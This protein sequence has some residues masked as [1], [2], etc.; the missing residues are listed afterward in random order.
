MQKAGKTFSE[1]WHRVAGLKVGLRPTVRVRKQLFRGEIWYILQDP[2]NNQFFR[3][4]PEAIDLV[5]RL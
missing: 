4:R 5:I 3:L 2:F 1:S